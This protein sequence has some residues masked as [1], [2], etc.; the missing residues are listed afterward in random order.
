MFFSPVLVNIILLF[1][2]VFNDR[3]QLNLNMKID[4]ILRLDSL[5]P[6]HSMVSRTL[7][8]AEVCSLSLIMKQLLPTIATDIQ[9]T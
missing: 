6:H 3:V 7:T 4:P 8:L 5:S 9:L 2:F 1:Y